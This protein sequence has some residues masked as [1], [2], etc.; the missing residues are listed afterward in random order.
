MFSINKFKLYS[1][2]YAVLSKVTPLY[3]NCGELCD[4]ACCKGGDEAGMYLFPGEEA[5]Y[6]TLP[7]WLKIEQSDFEY[8]DGKFAK[9]AICNGICDRALRPLSCRLFPLTP[10]F[11]R[12]ELKIIIDPRAKSICPIAKTTDVGQLSPEFVRRAE[13]A[14]RFLAYN[15]DIYTFM[16]SL[17]EM[18]DEVKR[19]TD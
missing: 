3:G 12:G 9:I 4:A 2:A 5:M 10:Y 16:R 17:S 18:I 13:Y 14:T 8:A 19:F 7:D 11:E 1:Q 6:A 15:S